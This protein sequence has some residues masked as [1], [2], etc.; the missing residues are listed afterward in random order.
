MRVP[1]LQ[2]T[3]RTGVVAAVGAVVL[4]F[5]GWSFA[6]GGVPLL[7]SGTADPSG[8]TTTSTP[9]SPGANTDN[10]AAA[11]NTNDGK[12]V[13][14]L[15]LKIVQTSA[16]E[17]DAANAAV[18]VASCTDCQTVAI[19]LEGVLVVGS[20]TTFDPTNLALAVN[21]GCT[22]CATLAAAYQ[23]VVQNDTRVRI[24]GAGRREIAAIRKDLESLRTSDLDILAIRDR[25]NDDAARFLQVLQNDVYPVGRPRLA[26]APPATTTTAPASTAG[27][28][29]TTASPA[30]SAPATTAAPSTTT[31][32]ASPPTT[33]TGPS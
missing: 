23:D 8:S 5:G 21:S 10:V 4:A 7:S 25:A 3:R 24:S 17:V 11:V 15:S 22:N 16:S 27:S 20:P 6:E 18:A 29:T 31:T 9:R 32:T 28:T 26:D 33:T 2:L 13:Y 14:A 1:H 12:T 30:T 19:A